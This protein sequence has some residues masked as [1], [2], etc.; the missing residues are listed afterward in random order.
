G[1]D[2]AA[3]GAW[4]VAIHQAARKIRAISYK[5]V[6]PR[7]VWAGIHLRDQGVVLRFGGG[8]SKGVDA[9]FIRNTHKLTPPALHIAA[10]GNVFSQDLQ[11]SIVIAISKAVHG[12]LIR[13]RRNV[14][15][16]LDGIEVG[17]KGHRDP[18]VAG[19]ALVAGDHSA[20]L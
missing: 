7:A 16:V 10:A 6:E 14:R 13:V 2:A 12:L 19:D 4:E 8:K 20:H 11:T 3:K 9:P 5:Q 17:E 15:S 1:K 18:V